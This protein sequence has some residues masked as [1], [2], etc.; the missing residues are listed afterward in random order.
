[1]PKR[2]WYS[3]ID[4]VWRMDNL[5]VAAERVLANKGAGGV[6][7]QTCEAFKAN[8]KVELEK[9]HDE[10][11]T[12]TYRPQPVRRVFIPKANGGQRGLGVPAVRDRVVQQALRQV[13][14][15]I[16]EEKFLPCSYGF[17]EGFSAHMA[18]DAISA[19]LEE[20]RVWA[21]DADLKSYFD[22][23]PHDRLI[24][25]VAE[26]IADSSILRLIR[27]FLESGIMEG[28]TFTESETGTPQ[29]GVISPLLAN[30]YLHAFD[31]RMTERGHALIRFAD[32]WVILCRSKSAAERVMEGAKQ[33]LE[34]EL[35]LT[36]HPEKSRV[37][38]AMEGFNF[39]GYS[40]WARPSDRD[41][42]PRWYHGRRPSDKSLDRCQDRL[43]ELTRRN[44]TVSPEELAYQ[45][46]TYLQG[47]VA[48]FHRGQV[49]SRFTK[50][51]TWLRRR[52]RMVVL[53]SWRSCRRVHSILIRRGW[54][55]EKLVGF[56]PYRWRNSKCPMV[57]AALDTQ[58]LK[59]VGFSGFL[60][61]YFNLSPTKG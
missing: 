41:E 29:G 6:D 50:L 9:L 52:Y 48:Y 49:K 23:I 19:A 22:T 32:D 18:L 59:S 58:W 42:G 60:D 1:M 16:F 28:G 17:R 39:L 55:R 3:L 20:G 15:P 33:F 7:G 13:I 53:R 2:K 35:G 54:K 21:V 45:I 5:L 38:S 26:E 56:S 8:L 37:V 31:V 61:C 4:K 51:D 34:Q 25:R 46:R 36:V 27:A 12:K 14:E 43:R 44:Q 10:L 40:F 24:D 57:H 47:W 30:I 11:R